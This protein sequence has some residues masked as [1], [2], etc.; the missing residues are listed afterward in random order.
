M[1]DSVAFSSRPLNTA[2]V[3][4]VGKIS[5]DVRILV[6]MAIICENITFWGEVS[7]GLSR[8]VSAWLL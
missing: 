4:I 2:L 6:V 7:F 5:H 8:K 1:E 3:K